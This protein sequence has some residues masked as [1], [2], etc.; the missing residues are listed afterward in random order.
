MTRFL[1]CLL[2][3]L[4]ISSVQA[5]SLATPTCKIGSWVLNNLATENPRIQVTIHFNGAFN[6]TSSNSQFLLSQFVFVNS[7][8]LYPFYASSLTVNTGTDQTD[9]IFKFNY[10]PIDVGTIDVSYTELPLQPYWFSINNTHITS[11]S[12][13]QC[14][15]Y[16][17][18]A[19][20][21]ATMVTDHG[22][23]QFI[24]FQTARPIV[25]CQDRTVN[26][27]PYWS[28]SFLAGGHAGPFRPCNTSVGAGIAP[29]DA[30][31]TT[32]YC[33]LNI[34]F[35]ST[36]DS[37]Y[38]S[39]YTVQE[40]MFCDAWDN[41]TVTAISSTGSE[42]FPL[43]YH[44][45]EDKGETNVMGYAY[46]NAQGWY[47]RF[48]LDLGLPVAIANFSSFKTHILIDFSNLFTT[49]NCTV[50]VNTAVPSMYDFYCNN[51]NAIQMGPAGGGITFG[52]RLIGSDFVYNFTQALTFYANWGQDNDWDDGSRDIVMKQSSND[53]VYSVYKL[54]PTQI[55]IQYTTVLCNPPTAANFV[56]YGYKTGTLYTVLN[57][58][59]SPY[60]SVFVLYLDK[61]LSTSEDIYVY[62]FFLTD[63]S[64]SDVM[65]RPVPMLLADGPTKGA[66]ANI[67]D[68]SSSTQAWI[69]AGWILLIFFIILTI[70]F[71]IL[72]MYAREGGGSSGGWDLGN[73]FGMGDD[74]F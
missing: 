41:H 43:F 46:A 60:A 7:S 15:P 26:V 25:R 59:R 37:S 47:D 29:L 63:P 56:I 40:G 73:M 6:T 3:L 39:Y 70:I 13:S 51:Y 71:F 33:S 69:M 67:S 62:Q 61:A 42:Y 48:R 22:A 23:N 44:I 52:F 65:P 2:L 74:S 38:S 18:N 20:F 27:F 1:W 66:S 53:L 30:S 19:F 72:W 21:K 11:I 54:A 57:V 4:C 64:S 16:K 8:N 34:T 12:I 55:A 31:G 17:M 10:H 58:V 45:P 35:A 32:F 9:L 36:L 50:Y 5:T 28:M 68:L 24:I 14:K 49:Y